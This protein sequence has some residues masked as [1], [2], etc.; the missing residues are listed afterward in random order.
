MASGQWLGSRVGGQPS[1]R[2][3]RGPR[4]LHPGHFTPSHWPLAT[5]ARSNDYL[6]MHLPNLD[7]VVD[8]ERTNL[9]RVD[10]A[11]IDVGA[12]GAVEIFDGQHT[13]GEID[14]G[15]LAR[16]PH[17]LRRLLVFEVDVDRFFVGPADEIEALVDGV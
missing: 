9:T 5:A 2:P 10:P 11:A 17:A 13:V 4:C 8:V 16:A 3:L 12:V 15:V 1:R 6:Q 14:D 7:D